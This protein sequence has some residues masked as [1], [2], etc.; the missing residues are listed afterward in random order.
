MGDEHRGARVTQP[1][2]A[3][4]VLPAGLLVS[5]AFLIGG[6][7]RSFGY[8]MALTLAVSAL[9]RLLLPEERAGGLIVRSRPWD[10]AMLLVLAATTAIL[11]ASLVIR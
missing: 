8:A 3:W 10:V 5:V 11:S 1:L 9:I 4:W 2:G 6:G 7:L